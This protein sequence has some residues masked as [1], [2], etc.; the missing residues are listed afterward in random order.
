MSRQRERIGEILD[1]LVDL[2]GPQAGGAVWAIV[3]A[4]K[5]FK[6]HEHD[7]LVSLPAFYFPPNEKIELNADR[8]ALER[9]PVFH[10]SANRPAASRSTPEIFR[11]HTAP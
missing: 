5:L 11:Y 10:A 1:L 9:A 7:Y 8:A 6:D 2:N 4:G 3:S